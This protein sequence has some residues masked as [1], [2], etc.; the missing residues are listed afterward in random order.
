[1]IVEKNSQKIYSADSGLTTLTQTASLSSINGYGCGLTYFN[2]RIFVGSESNQIITIQ[3]GSSSQTLY[4]NICAYAGNRITS[5]Y[6]YKM[7]YILATCDL[8]KQ[9][10][11]FEPNW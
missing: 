2:G 5:I 7:K 10:R 3:D 9:V 6:V 8:G 11:V 4:N 1:M